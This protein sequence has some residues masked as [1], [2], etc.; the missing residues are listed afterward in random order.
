MVRVY[1][2]LETPVPGIE[3]GST[4]RQGVV[5]TTILDELKDMTRKFVFKLYVIRFK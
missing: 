5:L 4:P 2:F 1:N 3:P